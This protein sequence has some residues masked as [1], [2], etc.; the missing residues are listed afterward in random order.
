MYKKKI[1]P[2]YLGFGAPLTELQGRRAAAQASQQGAAEAAD[3]DAVAEAA[4]SDALLRQVESRDMIDFG[5]IPEFVGRFPIVV[6]FESLSES[7]LVEI[8][9]RPRNAL[10]PQ[11]QALFHMDKVRGR[12]G[13]GWREGRERRSGTGWCR[14]RCVVD[15]AAQMQLKSISRINYFPL[16][17][18]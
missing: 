3:D 16:I 5:M 18:V 4:E 11:Y 15:Y 13:V 7:M 12:G 1:P 17:Q 10:V 8:L 9:T 6:P 2:Q 14:E